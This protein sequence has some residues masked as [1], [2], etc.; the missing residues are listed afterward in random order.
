M[1]GNLDL[2]Q[3]PLPPVD[4]WLEFKIISVVVLIFALIAMG[5]FFL[6]RWAWAQFCE[7]R[8]KDKSWREQQDAKREASAA[9]Q[10]KLWRETVADISRRQETQDK[11]QASTLQKIAESL[12]LL[13]EKLG[14]H[15]ERAERIETKLETPARKNRGAGS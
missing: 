4:T 12:V 15:D 6:L 3:V 8:D 5:A 7:E 14:A 1:G 13:H 9:E 11:E 2:F 10:N